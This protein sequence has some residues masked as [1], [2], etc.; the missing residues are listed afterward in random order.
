MLA[1]NRRFPDLGARARR[2]TEM[3]SVVGSISWGLPSDSFRPPRSCGSTIAT[4]SERL[5]RRRPGIQARGRRDRSCQS[6][7]RR[8][9][10][11][12]SKRASESDRVA[13]LIEQ[14]LNG[15]PERDR[16]RVVRF[17]LRAWL[18][19]RFGYWTQ[20][21]GVLETAVFGAVPTAVELP[22]AVT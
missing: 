12:M 4:R 9:H 22:P 5:P 6:D 18:D 17:L 14:S 21:P 10:G 1:P 13:G 11:D 16:A 3:S 20:P 15:L 8:Y 2:T 7:I 19:R